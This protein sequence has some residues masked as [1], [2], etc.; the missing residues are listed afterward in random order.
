MNSDQ[1]L[2]DWISDP[3]SPRADHFI[4]GPELGRGGMGRVRLAWDPFLQRTCAVK[5]LPSDDPDQYLQFLRESRAQARL[6]HPNVC[7][8]YDMGLAGE[9]PYIAMELLEGQTLSEAGP[10]MDFRLLAS[11]MADVAGAVDAAHRAGLIHRDL[12]PGNIIVTGLGTPAL[13]PCV[14]DFGL[15]QSFLTKGQTISWSVRGTPAFMSPEQARGEALGPGTDIYSLGATLYAVLT[16]QPPYETATLGDLIVRQSAARPRPV[17]RL[18][19]AVPWELATIVLRCLEWEPQQRYA[20]AKA[21]ET[22]L[23]LWLRGKPI[24]ARPVGPF[25][26]L[27]RWGR[28]RP[29]LAASL[30]AGLAGMAI[31]AGWNVRTLLAAKIRAQAA[32]R[33]GMK[34]RDAEHLLRIERMMPRHD[35]RPAIDRL[36]ARMESIR[37]EMEQ[38]GP[39]ARG[40]GHFALGHGHILL[41][42]YDEAVEDLDQA[43]RA[44][45]QVP[46]VAHA[47]G[48]ALLAR[49]DE[50]IARNRLSRAADA[51][52][53]AQTR[54]LLAQALLWMDRSHGATVDHPDLGLARAASAQGRF[55]EAD[56]LFART[57]E[58]SPWL[59]EA[60]LGRGDN[61]LE[62]RFGASG[63]HHGPSGEALARIEAWLA[64]AERL[65][66]SDEAV[67][68]RQALLCRIPVG[69]RRNPA[70]DTP[71]LRAAERLQQ[72]MV[73]RPDSTQ[74]SL[75][76]ALLAQ[77]TGKRVL[78]RGE[79]PADRVRT[80]AG[81]LESFIKATNG[82]T[83]LE[84]LSCR[85][86]LHNL[87]G[88]TAEADHRFGRDPGEALSR[89]RGWRAGLAPSAE[90]VFPLLTE[91]RSRQDR[92]GDPEPVFEEA[93]A[94]LRAIPVPGS[95]HEAGYDQFL[96]GLTWL[97][98]GRWLHASGRPC[99][100]ALGVAEARL[101]KAL[102][103]DPRLPE[104]Y[105]CLASLHALKA[106]V[107]LARGR[108][109]GPRIRE[110][111][112]VAARGVEL[113]PSSG[114]ALAAVA[115]ARLAEAESRI[116]HGLDP[117]PGL[118]AAR[119]A[120]AT[121]ERHTARDYRLARLRAEV[122]WQASIGARK[123]GRD[124]RENLAAAIRACR[125]GIDRKCDEP[126][127]RRILSR[128]GAV[129]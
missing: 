76:L 19:P 30:A 42:R 65:A 61:E 126:E 118:E 23:R 95:G 80:E 52:A 35:I 34:I 103:S 51:A 75:D 40:P 6:V 2:P 123:Q 107:D 127:F 20:S 81:R 78:Q 110:A 89:A 77:Q 10:G 85:E 13:R 15:A 106:R 59:Y 33:F 125:T 62:W 93:V 113:R 49:Y 8:I 70:D 21:L 17:R 109:P 83:D 45:F 60:W 32:Q 71:L 14:V 54:E 39:S 100:M 44:G 87:W 58:Q 73:I 128:I 43:W 64:A 18:N 67:L 121:A 38:L 25:G 119:K 26:S 29:Q 112:E 111:M 12:K 56:Q 79:D 68:S 102:E 55:E 28:R 63:A 16:G 72:A 82:L 11:I 117:T 94:I 48:Q 88:L 69:S 116:S 105:P 3:G 115:G 36:R 37:T 50:T 22:D 74:L 114:T 104:T 46:E 24:L 1:A 99:D 92:N 57:L 120:L 122:E 90:Q 53:D 129:R 98:W 5:L 97:E 96:A 91:A 4:L 7:R 124:P 31:L 84:R 47:M 101:K 27:W 41:H 86:L 66:P 9:H 108:D